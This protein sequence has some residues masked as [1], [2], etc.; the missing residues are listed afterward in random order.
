MSIYITGDCHGD[1]RRFNTQIFPE[2][3]EMTKNDYVIVC[4]DFGLWSESKEQLWWRNWL[5]A[6]P[7]TTLWVD[8]NHENYDL[9]Q[10]YPVEEWCGGKI[11]RI[12]PSIIHLMR[13]QVFQIDGCRIFTFGGAQ[14]HDIQGGVLD[15]DDPDFHEKKKELDR[16]YLPYRINHVSWWAEELPSEEEYQEGLR[17]IKTCGG[18]VDFVV[19]HC[20]STTAQAILSHGT[21]KADAL[22]DYF[23]QVEQ[24]L[25]FKK[26]FCGHY[27]DNQNIDEKHLLLY[28]Q[29]IRIW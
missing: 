24:M 21:Y 4:G 22:T 1:Y 2:Q 6:K 9:L 17:N 25:Q 3:K 18:E 11:H 16:G 29:I 19:S 28:E 27:H 20:V 5:D 14:S 23:M 7:F 13:G 8:G 10:Q 12:T 15:P 26:W